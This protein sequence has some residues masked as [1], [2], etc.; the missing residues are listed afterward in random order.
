MYRLGAQLTVRSGREPFVRLIVIAVAV[1]IGVA[2]MLAVLAD[3][4]AFNTTN[5]RPAW[6]NT[7]GHA[8]SADYAAATH[9]ELW[10]YGDDIYQGQTIERLDVAGLGPGAPV[11]PG[12]S[13]LPG[14]GQYYASPALAA[15]IRSVPA[16]ELGDRFPG[17]LIGT[18]GQPALTGPT[19]LVAYVGYAP[20]KL[21]T[22]P[23]TTLVSTINKRTAGIS[24]TPFFRDLFIAAAIMFL[25]PI[26]ILVAT[27]TRL[28]AARREERYAALRLVGATNR[29]IATI[30][31]VEAAISGLTGALLGIG[32]FA[33]LQP[34]LA[35]SAIT[36]ARYFADEVTPTALGYVLVL[37]GVPVASAIG[38]VLSLRRVR[39]SPLGVSRRVT[40]PPPTAWLI[41]PLAAGIVLFALG[42]AN[43]SQQNIALLLPLGLIVIMIGVVVAG[44]W[45]TAQSARL[46]GRFAGG[47]SALLAA[48]R[49]AD[50]PKLAFRSVRGLVLAV[51][52]CTIVGS[53]LPVIENTLASPRASALSNVLL[54]GFT[55]A[56]VC[57]NDANCVNNGA[58][59]PANVLAGSRAQ[60]QAINNDGLPAQAATALLAGLRAVNGATVI[61]VYTPRDSVAIS[62]YPGS[63]WG[64][65]SISCAGL[66]ELAVLGQCAPGRSAVV[67]VVGQMFSDNPRDS[68]EPIASA[69][70]PATSG[71]FSG[72]YLEA[73][74]VKVNNAATLEKVRTYLITHTPESASGT[75]PR[76]FGEAVQARAVIAD[77]VQRLIDTAVILTLVVAGCSLAV[78]VGGSLMERKR[79]FTL[80][81]VA[82]TQLATLYR[83]VLLEA[84]L[85]LAAATILAGAV[86]YF[87]A[88][89][90]VEKIAPAGTP[91]PVPGGV[92]YA[93]MG[94]GLAGALLVI[95]T[96]LPLLRR[97]TGADGVRFE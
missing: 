81:R 14:P 21:A 72:L 48:R 39:I 8:L 4:N 20:A 90:T 92:Y 13:R 88:S 35:D 59:T 45:I 58:G 34:A 30:A 50:N 43:T 95:L 33:A 29:Q 17:R 10:N 16:D 75:A 63:G 6:E 25:F 78:S 91:V 83:V 87:I 96:S 53:I 76:T 38:A 11:P 61:P 26:L 46:L 93:T 7:Q 3:F 70:S 62:A 12:I 97:L 64:P 27:A 77:T 56:P 89:T 67:A 55:S 41:A 54:D 68:T 60:Q 9:A 2:V 37:A 49:L 86:A 15:L 44:P 57:G 1:G 22:R 74:L 18:I 69:A 73:V 23:A 84:A 94:A 19:E 40:P 5:N 85:P 80:L 36:S 42:L 65:G 24:S 79:P 51:F 66:R 47:P 52:L 82:G 31:S 28:A 71:N 32:L